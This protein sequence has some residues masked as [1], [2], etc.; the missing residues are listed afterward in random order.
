MVLAA[1][2]LV[3]SPGHRDA[4]VRITPLLLVIVCV[5]ALFFYLLVSSITS[6]PEERMQPGS[7]I[8]I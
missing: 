2:G 4:G 5:V 7:T 1:F 8:T 6:P 3:L